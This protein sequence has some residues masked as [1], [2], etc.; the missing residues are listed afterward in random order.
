M[1]TV[2]SNTLT[3]TL[4]DYPGHSTIAR[5]DTNGDLYALVRLET[6]AGLTI[7]KTN[8]AAAS[9]S[10]WSP[11]TRANIAEWSSLVVDRNKFAHFVYRVN[12]SSEDRVYYRRCD[13]RSGLMSAELLVASGSNGGVSGAWF[14]GVDLAVVRHNNGAY[15]IAVAMAN[16]IGTSKY[17]VYLC[18]VSITSDG[19]IYKNNGIINGQRSWYVNGTAPG[20]TAPT[21]ETEGTADANVS[22]TPTTPALWVSWGRTKLYCVKL[23]WLGTSRGWNG[24]ATFQTIDSS[25]PAS[26]AI[27]AMW[28]GSRFIMAVPDTDLPNCVAVYQRNQANN[29]TT[30]LITPTHTTG[31]IRACG[32]SYE[33]GSGDL[34]VYAVGTSTSVLYYVDYVRGTGT[35]GVWGTVTTDA[36]TGP[37]QFSLKKG[38]T[39]RNARHD[40]IYATGAASPWTVQHVQQAPA[41]LPN[42]TVWNMSVPS[43]AAWDI[44]AG[45][46]LTWTFSDKDPNDTQ[47]SYAVRRQIGAGSFAWW[48]ASDS[49]WQASETFNTATTNGVTIPAVWGA[50][51]DLPHQYWVKA[52][53]STALA[54]TNYSDPYAV[55]ASVKAN[56][57]IGVPA[58]AAVITQATLPMTWTV[59]QQTQYRIVLR[60]SGIQVYDSGWV[61]STDT[62]VTPNY[63]LVDGG[64]YQVDL[65]TKNL[66][67]LASTTQT[68]SFT[69]DYTEPTVP[70]L[71][72]TPNTAAGWITVAV[73]N[74][75]P[76]GSQPAIATQEIYRRVVTATNTV[77]NSGMAGNVTGWTNLGGTLSYS[78]TQFAPQ[79]S[80][81]SA[82][83]VPTGA[84]ASSQVVVAAASAPAISLTKRY[85][86]SG[87][88][89]PDTV[90]KPM[91]IQINFYDVSNALLGSVSATYSVPVAATWYFLE[92]SGDATA[93][94]TAVK[95][96]PAVGLSSTPAAGDAF[97]ADE[98]QMREANDAVGTR[99][100]SALGSSPTIN[101]WRAGARTSYE[102]RAVVYGTNG[103]VQN[104]PWTS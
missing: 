80:P 63:T 16:T 95:A 81:G 74:P 24:P 60:L 102:Y 19:V 21:I 90:N 75:A 5:D 78:T 97:Y 38:G 72:C 14:Q 23:G 40:I 22:G 57:T 104:S 99:V 55:I 31:N 93:Y 33:V 29:T 89:R 44:N 58:A 98:L 20:R 91:V 7:R 48:R 49:T 66:E 88:I 62:A 15:A 2:S 12:E 39:G 43:G 1:A 65:T 59:S 54:P 30:T 6:A 76:A 85:T 70:A 64:S 45:L 53:D 61:T 69:V 3:S 73:T 83:L 87:W 35:W 68:R 41:F 82:R 101:D 36:L 18:G 17:G 37:T 100:A 71:V 56:P 52:R 26:D 46:P 86:V 79:S 9:W 8:S 96:G 67:G 42:T 103:G 47:G 34:R 51:A 13:L 25:I 27:A 50:D 32:M 28:D 4:L 92:V 11:M 84:A 94:P 77:T 10:G